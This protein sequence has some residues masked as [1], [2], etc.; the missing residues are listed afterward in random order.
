MN[1]EYRTPE[2]FFLEGH[3]DRAAVHLMLI[4][5]FTSS[6]A[7][8]RKL[9]YYLN[10]MGYTVDAVLLPGHGTSPE[11]MI[12]TGHGHWT[13]HVV[14]G[15]DEIVDRRKK[16]VVA[17]GH[18]MGGLLALQLALERRLDGVAALAAPI[19]LM[20]R[21]TVFAVLLQYVLKYIEK[22]PSV[23]AHLLQETWTYT[24][25]PI[26]CVVDL[27]RLLKQVKSKLGEVKTPIWI[28]QGEMDRLVHPRS[29]G[30]IYEHVASASKII[31]HYPGMSHALLL[32]EGRDLVYKDIH[33]FI[34]SLHAPVEPSDKERQRIGKEVFS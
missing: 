25:T 33:A 7:E 31:K 15:Y 22:K 2:P 23:S 10:D 19:F 8:F 21:K 12:K 13:G 14:K 30:Y 20:S 28:G 29:A 27:R 18:S 9:G 32:D 24:K 1:R 4:H 11:D 6:P 26:P 3:G 5:G 34:A 17:I 16:K